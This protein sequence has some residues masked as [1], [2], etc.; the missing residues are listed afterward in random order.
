M[1]RIILIF[2][3]VYTG[4]IVLAALRDWLGLPYMIALRAVLPA[5]G[6]L[7]A[8]LHAWGRLG[9]VRA[10]LLFGLAFMVS[11]AFESASVL[12]G[13]VYGQYHYTERLGPTF[14]GLV[15][16]LI[17]SSW[18]MML[19]PAYVI[20]SWLA[21]DGRGQR[22]SLLV[23]TLAGLALLSWDLVMEPL[24]TTRGLWV[25]DQP[26]SYFNIPLQN[27]AGWWLTGFLILVLFFWLGGIQP[28]GDWS[29]DSLAAALYGITI[30][31]NV[32]DSLVLGMFVPAAVGVL[33]AALWLYLFW[34]SAPA[35]TSTGWTKLAA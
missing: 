21:P 24:M 30:L 25:W 32:L 6:M 28:R 7:A 1:R 13:L 16:Y 15:P 31:G 5:V 27:F 33:G 2:L 26:G 4:L 35:G 8:L 12:T 19:Y 17:P 11:L 23:A 34:R 10:L 14:F 29:F 22:R 9:G 18:F 3:G 20:T